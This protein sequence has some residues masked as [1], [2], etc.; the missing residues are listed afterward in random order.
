V[1]F[2]ES[3]AP[4]HDE[5]RAAPSLPDIAERSES[6]SELIDNDADFEFKTVGG[7]ILD[8]SSAGSDQVRRETPCSPM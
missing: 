8:A 3:N 4:S 5:S 7:T 6:L 1:T 2:L